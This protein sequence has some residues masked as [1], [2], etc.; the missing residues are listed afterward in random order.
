MRPA[1]WALAAIAA[2][3]LLQVLQWPLS[4]RFVDLY[5]HL[6]V[7]KGFIN[8]GGLVTHAS[9]EYAPVGRTHLYPPLLPL[10]MVPF[11]KAGLDL[12][13]IARLFGAALFPLTL[14][15]HWFVGRRVFGERTAVWAAALYASMMPLYL[16]AA[17]LP[18]FTLAY[19]FG[20]TAFYCI[21]TGRPLRAG[22]LLALCFYTHTAGALVLALSFLLYRAR[23]AVLTGLALASPFLIFQLLHISEFRAPGAIL[24][25]LYFEADPFMLIA[26]GAGAAA[27]LRSP[28]KEP[29]L[30]PALLTLSFLPMALV[31]H[32]R[33]L[34]DHAYLGLVW[35]AGAALANVPGRTTAALAAAWF[36]LVSPV[37]YRDAET[38]R[39]HWA[40]FDRTAV[41]LAFP[42]TAQHH[43]S[44]EG[45]IYF[46]DRYDELV[47]LVKKCSEPGDIVWTNWNYA[48]GVV[49]LLA[50]R[51]T[52]TAMLSEVAPA[53]P[54]TPKEAARIFVFF[55]DPSV[56]AE[57][58]RKEV[59]SRYR[60]ETAGE[61]DF[62]FVYKRP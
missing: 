35:L 46:K 8:A 60:L 54:F 32:T 52:A 62:A 30:W 59:V 20:L 47:S 50:D 11:Y 22:V 13:S 21:E 36:V 51:P 5:Y 49:A 37:V 16:S 45:T 34:T 4:P 56:E 57:A 27:L 19:L 10:L 33:A 39:W 44:N 15:A 9:W 31:Y 29:L 14:A 24:E 3:S 23:R 28:K 42:S 6:A 55:K 2:F 41:H 17:T 18:A 26:A 40:V 12:I 53:R 61:T 1:F 25:N 7:M 48:G 43:R 58:F 38:R